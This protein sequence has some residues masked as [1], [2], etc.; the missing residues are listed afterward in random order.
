M[1]YHMLECRKEAEV[2]A[3]GPVE[4]HFANILSPW[5]RRA[6]IAGGFG[7]AVSERTIPMEVAPVFTHHLS[8]DDGAYEGGPKPERDQEIG[9]EALDEP[10]PV[11]SSMH[12]AASDF[13]SV[14]HRVVP[15]LSTDTPYFHFDLVS[16]VRCAEDAADRQSQCSV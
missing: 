10:G 12:K 2:W 5:I 9:I 13:E 11:P 3:D 8:G 14:S 1:P 6:L 15:V 7:T 16:A 4:F